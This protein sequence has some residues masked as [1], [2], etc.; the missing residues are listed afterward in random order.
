VAERPSIGE[1]TRR[2]AQVALLL[3]SALHFTYWS[4]RPSKF[5]EVE[6]ELKKWLE[7]LSQSQTHITDA[8]IRDQ[9]K[10]VAKYLDIPEDKFKASAGWIEN[11][12]SRHG[13]RKGIWTGDPKINRVVARDDGG[14]AV[15]S[16]LNPA[17]DT[18]SVV[19]DN[20]P[21]DDDI[22][23]S[24]ESGES[25][26]SHSKH[27]EHQ[28]QA[29]PSVSLKPAWPSHTSTNCGSVSIP[30]TNSIPG[31]D[32]SGLMLNN[33]SE[34]STAEHR[35]QSHS[36]SGLHLDHVAHQTVPQVDSPNTTLSKQETYRESHHDT[37]Y[38][39]PLQNFPQLPLHSFN[40]HPTSSEA[41]DAIDKVVEYIDAQPPGSVLGDSERSA[42][43]RIRYAL[44]QATNPVAYAQET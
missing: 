16:P 14:D 37:T 21:Y 41:A 29:S 19:T 34:Q 30:S 2:K 40:S 23:F 35:H 11:F 24:V 32:S 5:P 3:F 26:E 39:T 18:Q 44:F 25:P 20:K 1:L 36:D 12:K 10:T 9:A 4:F 6:E 13:V 27:E 43:N 7:R 17:F 28:E 8:M 15:L 31:Q 38:D 22:E 42:L 33:T